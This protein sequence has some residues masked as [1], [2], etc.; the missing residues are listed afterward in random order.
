MEQNSLIAHLILYLLL[1]LKNS[2]QQVNFNNIFIILSETQYFQK[3]RVVSDELTLFH[4]ENFTIRA[5]TKERFFSLQRFLICLRNQFILVIVLP[6]FYNNAKI[7]AMRK[8]CTLK[9][10]STTI[11]YTCSFCLYY[12]LYNVSKSIEIAFYMPCTGF[13]SLKIPPS[14]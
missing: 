5:R 1:P 3:H 14:F 8:K 7:F 12:K 10:V 6:G 11:T 13:R 9:K 2:T 4:Y